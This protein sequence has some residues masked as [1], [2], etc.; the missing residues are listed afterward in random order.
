MQKKLFTILSIMLSIQAGIAQNISGKIVDAKTNESIPYANVTINHSENVISN[1]EGYFTISE[2]NSS[3]TSTIGFSY[4]GY[5]NRQMTVKELKDHQLIVSLEAGIVELENVN[6][7]N[8]KPDALSIMA[9]V[10]KHLNQH[11]KSELQPVKNKV[12]F[13]GIYNYQDIKRNNWWQN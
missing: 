1:A 3:D 8:I 5:Q 11:Y 13:N 10:K 9:E 6:V 12:F 2:S 4:L 7:S